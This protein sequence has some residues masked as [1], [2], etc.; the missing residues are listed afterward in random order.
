M[1]INWD[2]VIK[3]VMPLLTLFLGV[4]LKDFLEAKEK[5]IAHYGHVSS[6]KLKRHEGDEQDKWVYTHSVVV[7]N[8]GKKPATN[9]RLGH[10]ILPDNFIVQPDISYS[11]IELPGGSKELVFPTLAPK[12][13]ITVSYLYFPP[14]T[15][16]QINS[17]IESNNGPAKVVNVLLQQIFPKW[18]NTTVGVLMLT[19]AV[20]LLYI[21]VL[22]I[23]WLL[24]M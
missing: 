11:I 7:R 6:F 2:I 5:L 4:W 1:S 14:L 23:I 22:L 16:N 18:V 12:K 15:Y 8:A 9:L 19:G 20:T 3:I 17:H 21:L 13:E 10:N 24:N